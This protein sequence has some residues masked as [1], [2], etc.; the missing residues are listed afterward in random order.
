[1]GQ[2]EEFAT[3]MV[4]AGRLAD[5]AGP[6]R[7][8]VEIAKTGVSIDL[9]DPGIADDMPVGVLAVAPLRFRE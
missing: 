4:P 7:G 6:A 3:A 8:I 2:H 9:E 1:M 5:R